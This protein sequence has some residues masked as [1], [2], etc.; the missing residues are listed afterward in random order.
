M[1]HRDKMYSIGN[2]VN[3]IVIVLGMTDCSYI[4]EHSI[5]S[6]GLSNY[7]VVHLKLM[8]TLYFNHTSTKKNRDNF[9]KMKYAFLFLAKNPNY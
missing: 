1:G 6:I 3:G 8:L 9:K 4:C 5:K 7:Y 2:M